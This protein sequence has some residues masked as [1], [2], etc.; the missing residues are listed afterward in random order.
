MWAN[1]SYNSQLSDGPI[2]GVWYLEFAEDEENSRQLSEPVYIRG[3]RWKIS[4]SSRTNCDHKCLSFYL[5]C[6]AEDCGGHYL[7]AGSGQL[8]SGQSDSGQLS[9]VGL[10]TVQLSWH[11]ISN[12][13]WSCAWS[14][15]FIIVSQ[16]EG[17]KDLIRDYR[18]TF[19]ATNNRAG[20]ALFT[21]LKKLRDPKNGWYDALN[22]SVILEVDVI[23]DKPHGVERAC[24]LDDGDVSVERAEDD[25]F[26]KHQQPTT[27]P[28]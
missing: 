14:A 16:T 28:Q 7:S 26:E 11:S 21:S 5:Q 25:G 4:A 19:N 27:D 9:N 13:N 8:D 24:S 3:L 18:N 23:A 15:T 10:S 22:D 6:N 17:K 12:A 1:P 2:K 20:Y